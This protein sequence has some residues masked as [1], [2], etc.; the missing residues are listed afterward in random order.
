ML[1]WTSGSFD[2]PALLGAPRHFDQ[3]GLKRLLVKCHAATR[4]PLSSV[5]GHSYGADE[6]TR[7]EDAGCDDNEEVRPG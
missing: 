2:V 5:D 1:L 3:P 4:K 7:E 6:P